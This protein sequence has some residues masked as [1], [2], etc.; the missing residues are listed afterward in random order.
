MKA[1]INKAAVIL[2][3]SRASEAAEFF[4][5]KSPKSGMDFSRLKCI[6]ICQRQRYVSRTSTA[7]RNCQKIK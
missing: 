3:F 1:S 2:P 7:L 6:S 5:G 4:F